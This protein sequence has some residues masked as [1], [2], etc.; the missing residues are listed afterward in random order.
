MSFCNS[1]EHKQLDK[2]SPLS[3]LELC[4][5]VLISTQC[6]FVFFVLHALSFCIVNPISSPS[7]AASFFCFLLVSP[8]FLFLQGCFVAWLSVKEPEP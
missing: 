6:S 3:D 2:L 5:K 1:C 8:S 4:R 7:T